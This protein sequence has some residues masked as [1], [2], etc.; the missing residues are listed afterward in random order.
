VEKRVI[1]PTTWDPPT[2]LV[3]PLEEV[4]Q[5]ELDTYSD[6]LGFMNYGFD[7]R[8]IHELCSRHVF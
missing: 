8:T 1:E 4:W 6:A 5:H 3:T 7:V 2:E